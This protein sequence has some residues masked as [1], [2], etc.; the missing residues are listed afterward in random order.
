MPL[1]YEAA[2][3]LILEKIRPLEAET[4]PLLDALG[5][6]L[7]EPVVATLDLPR[8]DNSAMDG[9]ALRAADSGPGAALRVTG[10]LAAGSLDRRRRC[11]RAARCAS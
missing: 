7:A 10:Y 5:R 2:R 4:V 1:T 3:Q 9:Y 6:A 8:F 11:T